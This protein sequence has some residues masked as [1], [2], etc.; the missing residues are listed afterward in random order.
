VARRVEVAGAAHLV[1]AQG[2]V[3]LD[4]ER[5][6]FDGM[7]A[8]WEAQQ[9]SRLLNDATIT[10]RLWLV[11]R[12]AEF[13]NEYPWRWRAQD[14]EGF[15]TSLRSGASA[16]S[17]IR[18]YH[19]ILALFV[20]FVCDS[21]YGW[22][23]ECEERFGRAP[24]LICHEWNTAAH[25]SEFEGRPGR[26]AFTLGELQ[27]FFDFADEQVDRVAQTGRKGTV[28]AFRDAALFK[29]AYAWGLRRR[30]LVMLDMADLHRNAQAPQ[31]GD[32]GALH[33]R[34][35]NA[36]RGSPPK[37]RTVLSVHDWA[38][39]ALRQ[40]VEQV[41]D[42]FDPGG[43]P[44]LWMT[45]RRARVSLRHVNAR[46][47]AYRQGAGLPEE[48]DLHCLRHS[49]VTHLIEAGYPERFVTEQVGH[50]YAATTAIYTGVSDDYKNRV[51][52]NALAGA[53]DAGVVAG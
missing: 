4:P 11:R 6:V 28:A 21:R 48:L 32:C 35:G 23:E 46:F 43:H 37:R 2:V 18:G 1:L 34:W 14:V 16:H 47:A 7:L 40:Y 12:F 24:A 19:R 45:E 53:F 44:A 3:Q 22:V 30:E 27:R 41:R 9:R 8:G 39:D 50:A 26:R 38:V 17:T 49:Y 25:V 51:L 15:T 29:V 42:G 5:A 31:F 33:V 52:A 13:T 36:S 10:G 20:A